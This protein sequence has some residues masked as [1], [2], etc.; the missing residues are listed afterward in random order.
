MNFDTNNNQFNY[1]KIIAMIKSRIESKLY[2]VL[3]TLTE[4]LFL[5]NGLHNFSKEI[6]SLQQAKEL[7]EEVKREVE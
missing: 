1:K 2:L 7:L 4:T 3:K 6:T 5:A